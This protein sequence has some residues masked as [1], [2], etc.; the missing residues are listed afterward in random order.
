MTVDQNADRVDEQSR[1]LNQNGL[2]T[3]RNGVS[4]V[5][6]QITVSR[7]IGDIA[8]KQFIT[9]EPES[10][11]HSITDDD[12]VLILCSDGLL[13]VYTQEQL[14]K[15]I[16]E[17]RNEYSSLSEIAQR[18]TDECCT[19]YNCRDNISL[20]LIDLKEY[21]REQRQSQFRSQNERN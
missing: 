4:R 6:G 2:I 13:L 11:H 20:I 17:K 1:I 10:Y 14:A 15:E 8:H 3:C 21:L 5:D 7:A 9:S 19:N 12:E 18:I 16:T